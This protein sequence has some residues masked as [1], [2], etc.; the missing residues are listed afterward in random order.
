MAILSK[1]TTYADGTQVTA[2]NLNALVDSA[3]FASGAVDDSTTQL[4]SGAVIVK[5]LGI[6]TGKIA[7]SAVTTAK[8][9]DSNVTTAKIADSNVTKA[10]IENLSDYKVLGNVSGGAAAPAEVAILDEDN[11]ASNSATSLATQQSIKAYADSKVDGTGAGSFTTLAA[12]G[13]VTFDTTTLKVDS[14]NN[15]VGIGEASPT[16][17]LHVKSPNSDTAE[18]VAAFGN[19]DIADGLEIKTNGNGGSS[20]DW[21]FNAKNTRSLVFDT[22]QTERMRID[23]SGNVGIGETNPAHKLDVNSGATNQV[24]LFESTDETAYIELADNTGSAQLITLGSGDLRI[25]TGGSGAGNVGTSGLYITQGQD[26]GIGDD[27]PSYKLDVNGTGRFTGV[28]SANSDLEVTGTVKEPNDAGNIVIQGGNGSNIELY[29]TGHSSAPS[30]ANYDANIHRFRPVDGSANSFN[31]IQNGNVGIGVDT[32][33]YKLDVNGTTRSSSGFNFGNTVSYL[34]ESADNAVALRVGGDGPYAE[35]LDAGSSILEMGNA[36]GSLALTASGAEKVRISSAGNV[37]IGTNNPASMLH[38]SGGDPQIRLEDVDTGAN[39]RIS[40]SSGVGGI[41][42]MADQD[43][44]VSGSVIG[45]NVDGS[46]KVRISDSGNVGIGITNP[47]SRLDVS[48]NASI[49]GSI[50]KGSGSFKINHPLDSKKDTHNLVHSFLEG[51]QADLIYRGTVDLVDGVANVNIDT[52]SGM[53]DGTFVLLCREVQS[54]TTNESGW[55]AVRS[56]VDGNILTIEA[57]DNTCTDSISWMVVGERQDQ[58]MYEAG[59]TDENGKV[60]VEPLIPEEE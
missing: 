12:S 39:S 36:S 60:I 35:F 42:L 15:R 46:E 5:D 32:P 53:T 11:M 1:G 24:A 49:T 55:T 8:I 7:A 57:Q 19:G 58:H 31:I 4:S 2:T 28:L 10:K 3:T 9:A 50:S 38:I 20:L 16:K 56:S 17:L 43:N 45:F 29:V 23:S 33:S 27:T 26:V 44:A 40:A 48:G 47:T 52:A 6:A 22:N 37:G 54:F 25:A 30:Q 34:Y 59:W 41:F 51:P 13:D 18:T 14:S 21:G